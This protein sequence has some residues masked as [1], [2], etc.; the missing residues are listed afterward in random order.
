M[1][2]FK[3]MPIKTKPESQNETSPTIIVKY[4]RGVLRLE[5]GSVNEVN[6]AVAKVRLR[7]AASGGLKDKRRVLRSVI[8]RAGGKFP[9]SIAEVDSQDDRRTAVLGI[10]CVSGGARQAERTLDAA[11]RFI[12]ADRPD[13]EIVDCETEIIGGF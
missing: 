12:E 11:I 7:L 6:V 1:R 5:S 10:A 3:G 8:E 9:V 4:Q 2:Q 13:A